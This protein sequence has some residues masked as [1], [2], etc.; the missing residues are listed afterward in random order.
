MIPLGT[1]NEGRVKV[2][3]DGTAMAWGSGTLPVFATPAM[4]L[5]IEK[6]ASECVQTFLGE[7]ESTVGTSLD[8]QHTAPSVVGEEVFCRVELTET[9]RSRMVF[10][11]KVWDSAGEVGSGKHERFLVNNEKFMR[12]AVSRVQS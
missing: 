11:V 6:T 1:S 12:K 5:L 10:D 7:G 4:I 2:T 3:D 9:D 8:I